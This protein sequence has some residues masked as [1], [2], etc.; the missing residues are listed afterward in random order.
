MIEFFLTMKDL[1]LNVLT[2]AGGV[3]VRVTNSMTVTLSPASERVYLAI[4]A[5]WREKFCPPSFRDVMARTGI[6]STSTI[7]Y[8]IERL[9]AAGL[10]RV[11]DAGQSRGLVPVIIEKALQESIL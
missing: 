2:L 4:L 3:V 5:H 11:M 10:L 8:H 6:R 1:V 7:F 9:E